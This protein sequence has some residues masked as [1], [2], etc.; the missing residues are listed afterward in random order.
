METFSLEQYFLLLSYG[1]MLIDEAERD[2]VWNGVASQMEDW[3]MVTH[4]EL[5]KVFAKFE[6]PYWQYC[7]ECREM[8]KGEDYMENPICKECEIPK[9]DL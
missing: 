3:G 2:V 5:Y 1:T 4:K 6:A 7:Q 9:T 8:I